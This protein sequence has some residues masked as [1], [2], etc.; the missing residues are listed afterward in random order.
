MEYWMSFK[1]WERVTDHVEAS[2]DGIVYVERWLYANYGL[3]ERIVPDE[4]GN[5]TY[6]ADYRDDDD[7]YLYDVTDERLL[8]LFL[9][10]WA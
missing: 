9:L 6:V 10:R 8:T 7:Y 3:R 1:I 5:V 4:Y 2:V